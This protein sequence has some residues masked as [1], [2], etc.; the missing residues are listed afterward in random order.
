MQKPKGLVVLF[1]DDWMIAFD[2]PAG[3][4]VAP[5]RWDENKPNLM[6]LV[7]AE[8]SPDYA[9]VHRLDRETSGVFL[10]AKHRTALTAL[11]RLFEMRAAA[12][13]YLAV[14]RGA[15]PEARGLISKPLAD[16]E[17]QPGRMRV[18]ADGK[19]AETEYEVLERW[20]GYGLIRA[21]PRTGRTHQIRV[22]LAALGCPLVGD[23]FYGDGRGLFLS[24]LKRDYR[25]KSDVEHPLLG[26]AALHAESLSLTHPGT[27]QT[28]TI[29]SPLPKDFTVAIRYL[30]RFAA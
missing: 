20:R 16:D 14:I 4:L 8:L 2:K 24:E 9:N 6:Q 19:P 29:Q 27:G 10:C 13:R 26:R 7:H 12:K 3:L 28:V 1:E 11:C 17:A 21:V 5:D 23:A 22:H 18:A 15:P 30:R 25:H